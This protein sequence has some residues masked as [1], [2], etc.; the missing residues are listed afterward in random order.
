MWLF[1]ITVMMMSDIG[2]C[3]SMMAHLVLMMMMMMVLQEQLTRQEL[4]LAKEQ[5]MCVICQE[6]E[7]SVVL[8]PC[9]HLCLCAHCAQHDHLQQCPLCRRHI[10]HRISV[11]A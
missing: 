1:F 8:L 5:R 2:D 3:I 6:R 4:G 7:K 9:R 10:A 11:Y